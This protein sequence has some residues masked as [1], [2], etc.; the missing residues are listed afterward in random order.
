MLP[1]FT[2]TGAFVGASAGGIWSKHVVVQ[3][4]GIAPP[5]VP[6]FAHILRGKGIVGGVHFGYNVQLSNFV[7]GLEAE[8]SATSASA[9]FAY[10]SSFGPLLARHSS[11]LRSFFAVRGRVGLAIQRILPYVTGGVVLANVRNS[12]VDPNRPVSINRG[13]SAL[14]WALGA[15]LEY[16][17]TKK[18]SARVEYIYM[19]FPSVTR[20]DPVTGYSFRFFDSANL[21]RA[22][23][24]FH[25]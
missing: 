1:Q 7:F 6:G 4:N 22:G 18:W 20:M 21:V 16:A 24:N 2:W 3:L 12:V 23:L 25:F 13:D 10:P 11:S 19:K 14:G 5:F 15:G 9:R 17:I 8:A